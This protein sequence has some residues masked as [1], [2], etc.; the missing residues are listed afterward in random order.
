MTTI[1]K[2][3][4]LLLVLTA[5]STVTAT[6]PETR[7]GNAAGPTESPA[8]EKPPVPAVAADVPA[9]D[10]SLDD[11]YVI[12]PGDVLGI[13]VWQ[14]PSL[15][16]ETLVRPD[17]ALNFPLINNITAAGKTIE[18]LRKEL[19]EKLSKF[20][21]DPV[22]L[23]SVKAV[24]GNKI[25]VVGK[26]NR[27]GEYPTNRPV[28]VMQILSMA[29]GLSPYAS[30]NKIKILRRENGEMKS[31]PF[32]YSRVEKGKDLEQNIILRGGDIVVVP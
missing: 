1:I 13:S 14:E 22:V 25:Y 24:A 28:D 8:A 7:T 6:A 17:G 26:V 16:Q 19:T 10:K 21:P 20:V 4:L 29:G 31:I 9:T 23:V 3:A 11:Q 32:H 2:T 27:P 5:C 12:Q 18:Q 15:Q 30:V